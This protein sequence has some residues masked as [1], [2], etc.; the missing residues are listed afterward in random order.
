MTPKGPSGAAPTLQ[1]PEESA[2]FN[3]AP[4]IWGEKA[5]ETLPHPSIPLPKVLDLGNVGLGEHSYPS[6]KNF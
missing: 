6:N 3:N 5:I 2:P 4:N 1:L